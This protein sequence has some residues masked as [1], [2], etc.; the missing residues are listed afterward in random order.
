MA[1][2]VGADRRFV[3]PRVDLFENAID[4]LGDGLVG[5]EWRR[6]SLLLVVLIVPLPAYVFD[7]LLLFDLRGGGRRRR[8]DREILFDEQRCTSPSTSFPLTAHSSSRRRICHG[9][10]A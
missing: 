8:I 5:G 4:F 1:R 3:G 10:L 2:R 6:R 7:V 9:G